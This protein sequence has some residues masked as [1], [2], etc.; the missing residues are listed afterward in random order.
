[1]ADIFIS[2]K[3]E[4]KKNAELLA[5]ALLSKGWSVWWDRDLLGGVDYDIVIDQQLSNAKVVIVIWSHLSIKSRFVKDEARIA[6]ER[7][8]LVPVSFDNITPPIG[9]GMVQVVFLTESIFRNEKFEKLYD[10]IKNKIENSI[11]T[12]LKNSKLKKNKWKLLIWI[13]GVCILIA[14]IYVILFLRHN[15]NSGIITIKELRYKAGRINDMII[16]GKYDDVSMLMIPATKVIITRETFKSIVDSTNIILG[17]FIKPIDTTY[18]KDV[19]FN[20]FEIKNQY[21]RGISINNIIFDRAGEIYGL[22]VGRLVQ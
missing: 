14:A 16:F 3:N 7:N 1:M 11:L 19:P 15:S 21:R 10:S 6:L 5:K 20:Y 17:D 13:L 9:F 2:Y 12:P 4:D 18:V 22:Y 8:I